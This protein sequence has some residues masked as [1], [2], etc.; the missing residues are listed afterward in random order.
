MPFMCSTSFGLSMTFA[1][2][3]GS[4]LEGG[5][6]VDVQLTQTDVLSIP[7]DMYPHASRVYHVLHRCP[8]SWLPI[9]FPIREPTGLAASFL[10][11]LSSLAACAAVEATRQSYTNRPRSPAGGLLEFDV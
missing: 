3:N 6:P 5:H 10:S 4:S 7:N 8:I 11:L 2:Q 9:G 1:T